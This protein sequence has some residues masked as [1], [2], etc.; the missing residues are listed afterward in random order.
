[1]FSIQSYSTS[2]NYLFNDGTVLLANAL[3]GIKACD[4]YSLYQ[5]KIL[6]RTKIKSPE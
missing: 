4:M 2:L 1:M 3:A 5:Q 6:Y